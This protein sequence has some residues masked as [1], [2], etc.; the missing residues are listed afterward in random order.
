MWTNYL[1]PPQG[2][3]G[4]PDSETRILDS[5]YKVVQTV[6]PS[7]QYQG[8]NLTEDYHEFHLKGPKGATALISSYVTVPHSATY[9]AC[10]GSTTAYIST[11]VFSEVTTDGTNREIF[12]WSAIDHVDLQ[13]TYV[14]PGQPQVG[15]G[16]NSS[17]AFDFL[18]EY[19]HAPLGDSTL[20]C[21]SH[22]NAVDKDATGDYL[23]SSRHT[24]TI[25][26][27]AG[28]NNTQY[29]A[30]TVIWRLG[31]KSNTFASLT[32]SV[33]GT[34]NLFVISPP[35]LSHPYQN[36]R[37]QPLNA[38]LTQTHTGRSP[39]NTTPASTRKSL[40]SP[41]GTTQTTASSPLPPASPPAR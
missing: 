32:S 25:Y 20:T 8:Q 7:G 26:K 22:I 35:L 39:S 27:I 31:G 38:N 4:G 18:Y 16:Q 41:F 34:S 36:P 21:G 28:L 17:S 33:P 29:A 3:P 40:E 1:G 24:W 13:D 14:C 30:G 10:N 2:G 6:R 37:E 23:V 11:G 15:T 5:A 19:I 12:Q 9:P